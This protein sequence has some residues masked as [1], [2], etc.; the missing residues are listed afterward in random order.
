MSRDLEVGFESGA[1]RRF[2]DQRRGVWISE[3]TLSGMFDI[4]SLE[5]VNKISWKNSKEKFAKSYGN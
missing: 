5:K 2:L 1:Q 3:K 4:A